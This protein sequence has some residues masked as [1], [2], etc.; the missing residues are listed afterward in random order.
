MGTLVG[1]Q[2]SSP[3]LE[4]CFYTLAAGAILYV[5]GQLWTTAQRKLSTDLILAALVIGYLIG[6][7]VRPDHHV[8]RRL[9]ATTSRPR[10]PGAVGQSDL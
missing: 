1:Y 9:S 8:R 6:A 5:V 2:A 3:A 4:I 7:L 10:G